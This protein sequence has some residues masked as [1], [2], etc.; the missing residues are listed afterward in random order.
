MP[1]NFFVQNHAETE[2][3]EKVSEPD[4]LPERNFVLS[5]PHVPFWQKLG[6]AFAALAVA[7]LAVNV[8][9]TRVAPKV[10]REYVQLT[11]TP[12]P[13]LAE[14]REKLLAA[15]DVIQ[16]N[17]TAPTA[18]KA[19]TGDIVWSDTVQK[20]FAR[21]KGLPV[22]DK[23]KETYQIWIFESSDDKT[24]VNGGTFDVNAVGEVILPL[25]TQIKVNHPQ[26]F[27][28]TVEKPGGVVVSKREKIA[29]VA[30]VS[31]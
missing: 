9:Q 21:I 20:G 29:A 25:D 26:M 16:S 31:T 12:T 2:N 22:N 17:W 14:Q 10:E 8:W 7:I 1:E 27:A 11:P 4:S 19:V 3:D 5:S 28:V 30:K 13:T 6:W 23:T 24:P 18:D 15:T